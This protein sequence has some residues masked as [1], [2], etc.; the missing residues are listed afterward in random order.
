MHFLP[1]RETE[2]SRRR[3]FRTKNC[4][5]SYSMELH[6][7]LS[8]WLN[9][10]QRPSLFLLVLVKMNPF[11]VESF[12]FILCLALSLYA[13]L[14]ATDSGHQSSWESLFFLPNHPHTWVALFSPRKLCLIALQRP[15]SSPQR[16][17][18]AFSQVP[19]EFPKTCQKKQIIARHT[20]C[21]FKIDPHMIH[22]GRKL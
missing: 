22:H 21:P 5:W 18:N 9:P 4:T 13:S 8:K 17:V 7:V 2:G 10:R 14:P 1:L 6:A 11:V 15:T 12:S 3:S 19:R 20:K 16:L